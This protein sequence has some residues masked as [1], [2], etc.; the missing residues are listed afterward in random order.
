YLREMKKEE[1]KSGKRLLDVVDVHFY[2]QGEGLYSARADADAVGRRIR[3][4]RSLWDPTYKDESWI[5]ETIELLPRFERLFNDN[6][7]GTKLSIGEWNFGG[8]AHISGAIAM[9][10][11]LGRFGQSPIMASAFYWTYPGENTPAYWA[12]RAY[13]NYDGKNAHFL[14]ESVPVRGSNDLAIFAS[15][16]SG[17]KRLVAVAINSDTRDAIEADVTLNACGTVRATRTFRMTEDAPQLAAES[18]HQIANG[19]MT[20][21]LPPQSITVYELAQ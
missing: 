8:E 4:T 12:Y 11:A 17:H 9:A 14:E 16:D 13:R 1:Q 7:P 3:S 6:Y 19:V 2:P 21:V 18:P 10:D 20:D 5:N 15:R